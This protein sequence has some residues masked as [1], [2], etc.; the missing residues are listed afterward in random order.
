ML[1]LLLARR[2]F[3]QPEGLQP[4]RCFCA[5]D[6]DLS[7][8]LQRPSTSLRSHILST[9]PTSIYTMAVSAPRYRCLPR[10]YLVVSSPDILTAVDI[11]AHFCHRNRSP[12][13]KASSTTNKVRRQAECWPFLQRIRGRQRASCV[14]FRSLRTEDCSRR[15]QG[16]AETNYQTTRVVENAHT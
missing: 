8:P 15:T 11:I 16:Q 9:A 2:R 10:Q 5:D 13:G 14:A 4:I 12:T 7:T 1:V 3:W 6:R